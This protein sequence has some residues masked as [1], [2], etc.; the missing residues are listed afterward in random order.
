MYIYNTTVEIGVCILREVFS[1]IN[2]CV[3]FQ[4]VFAI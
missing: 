3:S 2:E 4:G 1:L